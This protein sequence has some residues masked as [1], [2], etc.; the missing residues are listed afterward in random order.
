MPK[1][2][3]KTS[4]TKS[5]KSDYSKNWTKWVIIYLLIGGLLYLAVYYIFTDKATY[6][7]PS[8]QGT[9]VYP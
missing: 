7:T 8:D 1:K 3:A 5:R 9:S 2:T 4:S 6:T